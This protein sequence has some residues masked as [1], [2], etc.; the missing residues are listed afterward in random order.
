ML[1][2]YHN[3]VPAGDGTG[4]T[5]LLHIIITI[6]TTITIIG[7]VAATVFYC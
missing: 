7:N 3:S 4:D 5:P 6:T 2:D 1:G